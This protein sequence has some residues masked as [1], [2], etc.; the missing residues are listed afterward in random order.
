[1]IK[2]KVSFSLSPLFFASAA[3]FL[4]GELCCNYLYALLFS[5]LHETGHL[6]A[7]LIFGVVP[8]KITLEIQGIRIDKKELRLSYRQECIVALAG[9]FV[10]FLF[11]LLSHTGSL[12][13]IINSGLFFINILPVKTLDGGRFI[14]NL[15]SEKKDE[16]SAAKAIMMLETITAVILAVISVLCIISDVSNTSVIFFLLLL[17]FALVAD[18]LSIYA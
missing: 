18:L 10:N 9:P 11:M 1:M 15:I 13:F 17:I 14:Y 12:P 3:F 16:N 6:T 5:F 4:S 2:Q 7:M 8:D